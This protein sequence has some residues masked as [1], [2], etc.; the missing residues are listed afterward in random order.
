MRRMEEIGGPARGN[1]GVL[2]S[3]GSELRIFIKFEI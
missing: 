3:N 2:E 1:V